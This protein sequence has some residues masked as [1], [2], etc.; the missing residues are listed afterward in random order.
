MHTLLRRALRTM[1]YPPLQATSQHLVPWSL[2]HPLT[3]KVFCPSPRRG[4]WLPNCGKMLILLS[5]KSRMNTTPSTRGACLHSPPSMNNLARRDPGSPQTSRQKPRSYPPAKARSLFGA[6]YRVNFD[7]EAS[8]DKGGEN[9]TKKG[10]SSPNSS[11]AWA[12]SNSYYYQMIRR[13]HKKDSAQPVMSPGVGEV[14]LV[15]CQVSPKL[16]QTLRHLPQPNADSRTTSWLG[17]KNGIKQEGIG[18]F[19]LVHLLLDNFPK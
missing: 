12:A 5:S 1:I 13:H 6:T 19:A 9:D 11:M 8:N 15:H 18:V 17:W 2:F 10:D 14:G 16:T 7:N 3:K 4:L